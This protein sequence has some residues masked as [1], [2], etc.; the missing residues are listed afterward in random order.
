MVECS[1]RTKWL[2]VLI[3]LQSLKLQISRL[4][5]AG[6]SFHIQ[7]TIDCRFTL[8][9]VRDMIR[10]YI[11]LK[12]FRKRKIG[13]QTGK[14]QDL[15]VEKWRMRKLD[16]QELTESLKSLSRI[17]KNFFRVLQV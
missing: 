7:D 10:T 13:F 11:H 9:R 17:T 4:F 5:R 3:P 8:K 12:C 6:S 16:F 15:C 1:L 14:C 2:W